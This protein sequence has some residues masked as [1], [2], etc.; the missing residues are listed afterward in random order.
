MMNG[1]SLSSSRP[2]RSSYSGGR[3]G[4]F[5]DRLAQGHQPP[6]PWT[7]RFIKGRG[8]RTDGNASWGPSVRPAVHGPGREASPHPPGSMRGVRWRLSA[9]SGSHQLPARQKAV[10]DALRKPPR[11]P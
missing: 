5:F 7:A 2:P 9:L 4:C 10:D 1:L 3:S 6:T 8:T 11:N